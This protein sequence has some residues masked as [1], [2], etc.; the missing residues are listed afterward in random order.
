MIVYPL[1]VGIVLCVLGV[2]SRYEGFQKAIRKKKLSVDK[3][4]VVKFYSII[5]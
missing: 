2:F 4:G 3:E 1:I 5:L